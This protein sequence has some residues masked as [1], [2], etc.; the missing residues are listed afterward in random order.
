[1][2][3][4]PDWK[5]LYAELGIRIDGEHLAFDAGAIDAAAREVITA[6]RP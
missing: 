5:K 3:Q 4:F 2:Q 1:M 6:P